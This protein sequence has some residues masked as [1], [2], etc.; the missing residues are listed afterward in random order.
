M[1]E[2]ELTDIARPVE[3][4]LEQVNAFN[5]RDLERFVGTYSPDARV[6]R[7]DGSVVGGRDSLREHYARRLENP[8]IFCEVRAIAEFGGRWVVAHEF[9]SDGLKTTEVV[10]TFEIVNGAIVGASLVLS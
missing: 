6:S 4:F 7:N 1:E 5:S 8:G 2:Y 10:A 3:V 9:V